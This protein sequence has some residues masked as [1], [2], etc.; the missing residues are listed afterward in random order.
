MYTKPLVTDVPEYINRYVSQAPDG[1]FLTFLKESIIDMPVFFESIPEDKWDYAY[2]EGKWTIKEMVAHLID[3]ERIFAYR[4]LCFAR[5]DQ[6]HF[7][8]YDED[9]Y[10]LASEANKR[11]SASLINEW[12]L[13][14]KSTFALFSSFTPE[15]MNSLGTA[16]N[17][18]LTPLI[19]GY[20]LLGHER[21]HKKVLEERYL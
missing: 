11:S 21:H 2:A 5:N 6:T 4:A 8:S 10:A 18:K 7:P 20:T 16:S 3:T 12:I 15:M 9:A 1:N 17:Y 13:L 19:I 14:R